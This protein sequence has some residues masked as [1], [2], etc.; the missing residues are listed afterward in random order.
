MGDLHRRQALPQRGIRAGVAG[1]DPPST[2]AAVDGEAH[3]RYRVGGAQHLD[4]VAVQAHLLA[5][6]QRLEAQRR[7]LGA[8]Q[9]GEIGPDDAVEDV[10]AQRVQRLGQGVDDDR[11]APLAATHAHDAVGQ[12]ADREHVVEVGMADEDVVDAGQL[13]QA[14]VA[15]AG[16]GVDQDRLVEQERRGPAAGGDGPGTSEDANDHG[17][18]MTVASIANVDR[19]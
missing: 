19:R 1:I 9:A 5:H 17:E 8:R 14:E 6:R 11:A 18:T 13:V 12:Q 4:A 15:D 7:R 3:R 16:A 10:A 2:L